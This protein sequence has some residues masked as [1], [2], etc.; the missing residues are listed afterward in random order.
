MGNVVQ[1]KRFYSFLMLYLGLLQIVPA[2]QPLKI[3]LV[4]DQF[5]LDWLKKN[6]DFTPS[7]EDSLTLIQNLEDLVENLHQNSYLQASIDSLIFLAPNT[8]KV[9]LHIGPLFQWLSLQPGQID[10]SWLNKIGF[11]SKFYINKP[12]SLDQYHKIKNKLIELAENNGFPFAKVKFSDVQILDSLV[13]ARLNVEQDS[14]I[15]FHE[16]NIS[17]EVPISET[18][19]ENYLGIK[20]DTPYSRSKIL[21]L[22]NR[23]NELPFLGLSKDPTIFF[24][25]NLAQINLSLK[26]KQSSKFDFIIGVLPNNSQTGKILI[27]GNFN[28]ELLNQF[29]H[30]ERIYVAFE[31]LRPATQRVDLQFNYPYL[32][33]LPFGADLK[34]NLYKRDSTFIDL[35]YYL[36]IQYL[37]EGGNYLKAFWNN[38]SSILLTIN[39]ADILSRQRLP[40]N[41]DFSNASFGLEW[42]GQNLDYKFNPRKGWSFFIRAASGTKKIKPNNRIKELGIETLYD[43]IVLRTAQYRVESHLQ[44]YFPLF[45]RSTFKIATRLGGIITDQPVFRNEQFR[46]GG[47]QILR[48]FDEESVFATKFGVLTGEYRLLIGENAYLY[49]FSDLG[50]VENMTKDNQEI[51][52]MLGFGAGITFE[53]KVGVFG[54]S[55]AYGK[56]QNNAL[57]LNTPKLHFGYV[58]LF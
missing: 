36:G 30:G 51:A 7:A 16:L 53:T 34:F 32:L 20:K 17:G 21:K 29:A 50:Y 4:T 43:S 12:F 13:Q 19:L 28:G 41:L 1:V 40:E 35:D 2:Q 26:K 46:I 37:L 31:Q 5:N 22:K 56:Q 54:L 23:I 33:K 24:L 57:D 6:V 9:F 27:T 49:G 18:Y 42:L 58:S 3:E 11:K 8:V 48:G 44:Y 14:F 39:E 45:D 55:L 52:R 15:T 38:R 25:E 10:P 47:N